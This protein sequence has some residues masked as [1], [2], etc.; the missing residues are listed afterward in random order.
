MPNQEVETKMNKTTTLIATVVF[1][2]TG[3]ITPN[4]VLALDVT[5]PNDERDHIEHS[6][7]VHSGSAEPSRIFNTNYT[8][9][10][11]AP[12]AA[13]QSVALQS[14]R[15]IANYDSD[16]VNANAWS[17]RITLV[18][19]PRIDDAMTAYE[20]LRNG[21][22][23]ASLS[24]VMLDGRSVYVVSVSGIPSEMDAVALAMRLKIR[25]GFE[26]VSISR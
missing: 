8:D 24:N 7:V 9:Q 12:A 13:R 16:G 2:M 20:K 4:T 23:P 25:L 19:E 17:W 1:A 22:Y 5:L 10:G 21:G 6:R 14:V 26:S 15:P 11:L 3:L 18:A